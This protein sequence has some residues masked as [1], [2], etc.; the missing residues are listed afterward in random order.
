MD[1]ILLIDFNDFKPT[2]ICEFVVDRVHAKIKERLLYLNNIIL[3]NSLKKDIF[4]T[5]FH[6][7]YV[8]LVDNVN[9]LIQL[10]QL[11]LFDFIDARLDVDNGI[12]VPEKSKVLIRHFQN[13]LKTVLLQSRSLFH[14]LEQHASEHTITSIIEME[15]LQLETDITQWF[16]IVNR[17]ILNVE[18]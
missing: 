3:S 4:N 12:I 6:A 1:N 17:N 11:V 9:R 14:A 16:H 15:L 8:N 5:E 7:T 10:E 13:E 2:Q 18:K